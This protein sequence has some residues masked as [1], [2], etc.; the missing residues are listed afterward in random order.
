MLPNI[1]HNYLKIKVLKKEKLDLISENDN[2][3]KSIS[4]IED[5]IEKL[6]DPFYVET[7]ARERLNMVKK[8]EKIYRLVN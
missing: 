7:L 1:Y 6:N 5:E 3:E 8:D 4:S 2:L